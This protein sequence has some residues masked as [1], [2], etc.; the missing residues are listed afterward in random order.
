[1]MAWKQILNVNIKM[2]YLM[3]KYFDFRPVAISKMEDIF[4]LQKD[5]VSKFWNDPYFKHVLEQYELYLAWP[6]DFF[7][8]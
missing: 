5:F 8:G 7:L 4:I 3:S 1:M 2:F 6:V